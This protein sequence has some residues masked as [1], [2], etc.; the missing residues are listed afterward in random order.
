MLYNNVNI[1]YIYIY[2][3]LESGLSG[4]IWLY[5]HNWVQSGSTMGPTDYIPNYSDPH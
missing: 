5:N 2:S 3:D 1:I 4:W